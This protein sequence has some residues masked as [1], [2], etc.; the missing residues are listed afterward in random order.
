MKVKGNL[1]VDGDVVAD[2]VSG[3]GSGT[4]TFTDGVNSHTSGTLNV[5]DA[6]FYL[7]TNLS[8]Q[9]VL[10][11]K[12]IVDEFRLTAE[13]SGNQTFIDFNI[14]TNTTSVIEITYDLRT[15]GPSSSW[16]EVFLRFNLDSGTNY[17]RI[18]HQIADNGLSTTYGNGETSI[19]IADVPCADSDSTDLFG[20]GVITITGHNSSQYSNLIAETA[21]IADLNNSGQAPGDKARTSY[22]GG[23]WADTSTVTSIRFS[24]NLGAFSSGCRIIVRGF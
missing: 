9:P 16:D 5:S 24:S 15:G 17:T 6:D 11:F 12:P 10:N 20:T 18:F 3:A 2:N 19:K 4:I 21:A 7:S 1:I 13:L 14:P 23:V 8:G 22:A